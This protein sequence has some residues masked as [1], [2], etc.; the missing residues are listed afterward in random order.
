MENYRT[1]KIIDVLKMLKYIGFNEFD[2]SLLAE[3]PFENLIDEIKTCTKCDLHKKR[4]NVVFG[5]GSFDADIMIIGEAPGRDEDIQG[6]PFVGR[7][8]KKL[9]DM[10]TAAGIDEDDIFITNVVKCRPPG[11]RNPKP[12]EMKKCRPYLIKQIEM[13][14]PK[15]LVLLGNIAL[16]L[17]T[18]APSGITKMR[19][20]SL[21]YLSC[22]AIPTFH[23]AYVLRN[24]N[25]EK[26]VV[27]DFKKVVRSIS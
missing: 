12:I 9:R 11:N 22:K 4:N 7:A 25:S 17:V 3:Y 15:V 13:I 19:G 23:P 20:K 18:G 2:S 10:F 24:P 26:T 14:K 8:G 16:S 6:I 5:E 27:E 21:E 1:N